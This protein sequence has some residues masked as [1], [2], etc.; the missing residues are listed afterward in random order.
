MAALCFGQVGLTF[1]WHLNYSRM[2]YLSDI[3]WRNLMK[4]PC[5]IGFVLLLCMPLAHAWER[6]E[7]AK[8]GSAYYGNERLYVYVAHSKADDHAVVKISGINHPLDGHVYWADVK[9]Q[10]GH[11]ERVSYVVKEKGAPRTVFFVNGTSGTFTISNYRGQ[12]VVELRV[13]YDRE[14]STR[15]APEHLLTDYERQ[16]GEAQ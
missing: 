10:V 7:M 5:L 6:P 3:K 4:F 12:E 11:P 1:H 13:S 2:P 9:Y 14:E 16:I 15:V 8:Y